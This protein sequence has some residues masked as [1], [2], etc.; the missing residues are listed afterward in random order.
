MKKKDIFTLIELLV[1]I[2]I[3][4]ILAAMLLPAL[5]KAR[6]VAKKIKCTGNLKS[7]Q[8]ANLYYANDNNDLALADKY[9]YFGAGSKQT[10]YNA[11][12]YGKT[13][14]ISLPN[15][16]PLTTPGAYNPTS[17][18]ILFC[19]S[20]TSIT[21]SNIPATHFGI[22]RGIPQV[23]Y[24]YRSVRR[25]SWTMDSTRSFVKLTSL[26]NASAICNFAD[27]LPNEYSVS[28][29]PG[30][31]PDCRHS[32]KTSNFSYFDGHCGSLKDTDIQ[33]KPFT[34]TPDAS[35]WYYGKL[36]N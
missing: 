8:M 27:C 26:K 20:R 12:V 9:N 13:R 28:H 33:L 15:D 7:L 23:Y 24:N 17:K 35:P 4:A 25:I 31:R 6:E 14:Y 1:V 16:R 19:P 32:N 2:A 11:L 34:S 5:N 10:W 18:S 3:I 36:Y 29:D 22:N 30:D 21:T